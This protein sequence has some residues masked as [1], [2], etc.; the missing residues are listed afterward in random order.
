MY[1]TNSHISRENECFFTGSIF[2][3][4]SPLTL[5]ES[6][7]DFKKENFEIGIKKI[8]TIIELTINDHLD[9]YSIKHSCKIFEIFKQNYKIIARFYI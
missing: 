2:K 5:K 8:K 7:R 6:I 4:I 3:G 9:R 1:L